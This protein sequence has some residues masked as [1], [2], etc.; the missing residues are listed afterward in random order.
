MHKHIHVVGGT[1]LYKQDFL[2]GVFSWTNTVT[3]VVP[4]NSDS[5]VILCLQL[6][7]KIPRCTLHLS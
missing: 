5:D 1:L 4:T 7:S 2:L 6:L 3:T